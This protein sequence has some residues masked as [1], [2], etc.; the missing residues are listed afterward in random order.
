MNLRRVDL[1]LLV[2]LDVL[3]SERNVTVASE[4]LGLSQPAVSS[5]LNRLRQMFRD[6]LFTASRRGLVPTRRALD[7]RE[8][9]TRVLADLDGLLEGGGFDPAGAQRVFR[10]VATDAVHASLCAPAAAIIQ[11]AHPGLNFALLA[12]EGEPIERRLNAGELDLLLVSPS[13]MPPS[14]ITQG[15]YEERFLCVMR[16][17]HPSAEGG[18]DLDNFCGLEHALVSTE[19]GGFRGAVDLALE[20][21]GRR[22]VVRSSV[23]NF[24]VVPELLCASDMVATVPARVAKLWGDRLDAVDPPIDLPTFPISMGWSA[25]AGAD[26]GLSWLRAQL[27]KHVTH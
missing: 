23:P 19:G 9:L 20:R 5:R 16:R 8:P 15:L 14:A 24:L 10:V 3:L 7:L 21:I 12:P 25:R 22:R 1:N 27:E 4:R 26:E 17:G 6:R 11:A 13:M 18:F 2:T